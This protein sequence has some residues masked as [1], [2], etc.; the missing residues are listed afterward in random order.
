MPV[1]GLVRNRAHQ[2]GR[3]SAMGTPIAAKRR[4]P[5]SGTPDVDLQWTDPEFDVGAI[6]PVGSPVRGAGNFA[7]NLTAN[8]LYYNDL[9]VKLAALFGGGVTPSGSGASK[10]W[11]WTPEGDGSQSFDLFTYQFG[12][13]VTTDWYQ[14]ADGILTSLTI[15]SPDTGAGVLTAT[16]SWLFG[17]ANSTGSTD[18][19]VAGTVPTTGLSVD[20]DGTPVYLKDCS[21]FIDSTAA[22]IGSTMV[23]DSVHNFTLTMAQEIDQKR[24]ANGSQSFGVDDY[25]RASASIDLQIQF[26]KTADSVGTGSESDAWMSDTA[27][28]R[29]V[30]IQFESLRVAEA[31]SPDVPYSWSISLPMRY[32]T[33]AEGAIGGN[34][35]VVLTGHAFFEDVT[36]HYP[37]TSTL[38]NTVAS[39]GI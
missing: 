1:Q 28:N 12:D 20:T 35:T 16:E 34:S 3:Q 25:G 36:L 31:G 32:Y 27:V 18:S 14:L 38:V 39:A 37:I 10:T 21:V 24:Y 23:G 8:A 7:A 29:F 2:F 5:L 22:G 9:Q 13:D 19:P 15:N 26:A 6:Y 30:K 4:L 11:A 33:R 17:I